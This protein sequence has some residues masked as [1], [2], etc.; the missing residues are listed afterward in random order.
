MNF[1]FRAK[2]EMVFFFFFGLRTVSCLQNASLVLSCSSFIAMD[3]DLQEDYQARVFPL[4][5]QIFPSWFERRQ[6]L[7]KHPSV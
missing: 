2:I 3:L 6:K 5:L 4:S 7:C 1:N